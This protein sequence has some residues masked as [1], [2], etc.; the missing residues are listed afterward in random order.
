MVAEECSV[1]IKRCGYFNVFIHMSIQ[2]CSGY[3]ITVQTKI[4]K[5][6]LLWRGGIFFFCVFIADE[7]QSKAIQSKAKCR[8]CSETMETSS[9]PTSRCVNVTKF[10]TPNIKNLLWLHSMRITFDVIVSGIQLEFMRLFH[11][12]SSS[13]EICILQIA[14]NTA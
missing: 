13:Q 2:F 10:G 11:R 8:A 4:E 3:R 9:E 5:E 12:Q 7:E 14:A 6:T 1:E